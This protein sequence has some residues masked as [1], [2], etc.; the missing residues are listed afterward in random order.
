[1]L[2]QRW[3]WN[4][5]GTIMIVIKNLLFFGGDTTWVGIF[6]IRKEKK[7]IWSV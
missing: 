1:V 4:A 3:Y 6:S 7:V 5:I 2:E